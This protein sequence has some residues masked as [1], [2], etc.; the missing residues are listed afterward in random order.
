MFSGITEEVTVTSD[1]LID[2]VNKQNWE[3]LF[4]RDCFSSATRRAEKKI[5]S[6]VYH[7]K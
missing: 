6:Y 5:I 3:I 7:K 2:L 4:F 1:S